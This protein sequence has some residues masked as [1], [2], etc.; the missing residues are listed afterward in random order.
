V[1]WCDILRRSTKVIG[2]AFERGETRDYIF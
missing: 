2:T 1:I